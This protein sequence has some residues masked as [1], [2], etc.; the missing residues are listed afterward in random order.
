MSKRLRE[1]AADW[2]MVLGAATLVLS[3]FATWS[4]Q[5]SAAF[6]ARWGGTGLLADVPRDPTA[7]QVYS[8]ADVLLA[9]LAAGLVAIALA[10]RP[11]AR[12]V[13]LLALA[14]GVAFTLYAL[15]HPPT[16]GVTVFDPRLSGYVPNSPQAGFGETLALAGLGCG[17]AGVLLAFTAD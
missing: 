9:L 3:L 13:M 5:F 12:I 7:W 1:S 2:L 14:V 11:R 15:S 8:I 10:G 17:L 4:H 6:L 16:N